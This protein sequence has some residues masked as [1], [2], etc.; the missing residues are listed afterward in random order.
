VYVS[1]IAASSNVGDN[2]QRMGLQEGAEGIEFADD[3]RRVVNRENGAV[4][5]RRL[6]DLVPVR[7]GS[8]RSDPNIEE[9]SGE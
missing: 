8:L 4:I 7:F 9:A 1:F 3:D 6:G 2:L 5:E